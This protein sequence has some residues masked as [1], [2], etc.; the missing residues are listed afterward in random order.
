MSQSQTYCGVPAAWSLSYVP[1]Q[2]R[3]RQQEEKSAINPSPQP[4]EPA[5]DM[6]ESES[7]EPIVKKKR[8][9]R[10]RRIADDED[11]DDEE[12]SV[13]ELDPPG[14]YACTNCQESVDGRSSNTDLPP[15]ARTRR[16]CILCN[17][18]HPQ[19]AP[20]EAASSSSSSSAAAASSDGDTP[21][22]AQLARANVEY[23]V[24]DIVQL[25][26]TRENEEH[27]SLGYGEV[28]RMLPI[29]RATR[30][31]HP[32]YRQMVIRWIFEYDDLLREEADSIDADILAE[33]EFEDGDY[34][35]S[36]HEQQIN[37][38]NVVGTKNELRP[39]IEFMWDGTNLGPIQKKF[40]QSS[41]PAQDIPRHLALIKEFLCSHKIWSDTKTGCDW[42]FL[43]NRLLTMGREG[44]NPEKRAEMEVYFFDKTNNLEPK[45]APAITWERVATG[46]EKAYC[47]ACGCHRFVAWRWVEKDWKLGSVC[48]ERIDVV[49]KFARQLREWRARVAQHGNNISQFWLHQV[50][51]KLNALRD[52][53]A[54]AIR[55]DHGFQ[56]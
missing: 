17:M 13:I 15:E 10:L 14:S 32:T 50:A 41:N 2:Q 18:L 33:V 35:F 16:L 20:T 40:P 12:Q 44:S 55:G 21:N 8:L 46:S 4:E 48:K 23:Q 51:W 24:G 19:P 34:A 45:A 1:Q 56:R 30:S 3:Q 49:D 26:Y 47:D 38:Y 29:P 43:V 42:W 11:D 52:E 54:E 7:L 39:V 5:A 31:G 53:A 6:D 36:H 27:E 25:E 22:A 28:V 37:V 9:R